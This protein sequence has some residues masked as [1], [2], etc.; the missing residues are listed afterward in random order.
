MDESYRKCRTCR[1]C[2]HAEGVYL[3]I[4]ESKEMGYDDGCM[5]YRPGCCE[6]CNN[7]S[8]GICSINGQKDGLDVCSDYDPSGAI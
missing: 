6:N 7:W 4:P 3:C 1:L 5:R 8:S 2:R